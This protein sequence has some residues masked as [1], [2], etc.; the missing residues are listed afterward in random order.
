MPMP[1]QDPAPTDESGVIETVRAA[2]EVDPHRLDFPPVPNG[3]DYLVSVVH[4][5]TAAEVGPR[6][7]KYAVL[8][9]QAATE[10][11]LKARLVREHWSLVFDDP[12]KATERR[13][14]SGDFK[15]CTT[16]EAVTRLRNIADVSITDQADSALKDLAR[17]RNALQHFGL[18]HDARAV[19]ARAGRVLDFLVRFLDD[20][21]LPGFSLAEVAAIASDVGRIRDGLSSIHA[22]VTERMRRLQPDLTGHEE[23]TVAC[24]S[25]GQ[26]AMI[27]DGERNRCL[28][29][30]TNEATKYLIV[31]YL[32]QSLHNDGVR[33]RACPRCQRELLVDGIRSAS[34]PDP[35]SFCFGCATRIPDT[36]PDAPG[37]PR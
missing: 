28:F 20:V 9:L 11:L 24:Y 17:D 19:E 14:R 4:H 27:A 2:G 21:L 29:C 1:D 34:G 32:L 37:E 23:R 5:L 31:E 36:A 33:V 22:F 7:I 25:C 3:V 18:S 35:V 12:G 10:V 8:H 26:L 30:N 6:D 15:S 16:T 13:F